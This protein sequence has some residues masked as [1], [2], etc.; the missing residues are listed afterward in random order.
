MTTKGP[1]EEGYLKNIKTSRFLQLYMVYE[2]DR[3][4]FNCFRVVGVKGACDFNHPETVRDVKHAVKNSGGGA[5]KV[6]KDT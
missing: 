1:P 6:T 4:R 5:Q 3:S 2:V